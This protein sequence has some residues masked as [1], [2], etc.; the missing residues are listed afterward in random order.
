MASGTI[1]F[2]IVLDPDPVADTPRPARLELR[3]T[4]LGA[5][6]GLDPATFQARDSQ[7]GECVPCR[8]EDLEALP[9]PFD[10]VQGYW[11]DE[12]APA[13]RVTL[14]GL[15]RIYSVAAP[16][17][18]GRL[19]FLHQARRRA[20]TYRVRVQARGPGEVYRAAP[21]PWIGDGDPLFVEDAG[22]LGGMLHARPALWDFGRGGPDLLV[23]NI[24]GHIL[25]FPYEGDHPD[26]PYVT[27]AFV[28]ADGAN[29]DVGWYAAPFVCDWNGN[30]KPDLLVGE[31]GRVIYYENTGTAEAW[32]LELRGPVEA[33]GQP[34]SIPFEFRSKYPYIKREYIAAPSVFDWNG[35][36][37]ADLVIGGYL[38]GLIYHY[39][40]VGVHA[41]GTP[42]LSDAGH[43]TA[44]GEIIDVDWAAAP[45]FGDFLGTGLPCMI[46]GM[47][48][49]PGLLCYENVGTRTRPQLTRRPLTIE[50]A[51]G[52]ELPL[53][54][55][56][57]C[58]WDLNGN[59]RLDL[60]VG[61]GKAV[62][63]LEH[64]D[65]A[66]LAF[67]S[68]G[69][70]RQAWGA[71]QLGA[72]D[73][74]RDA[75]GPAFI[76][77]ND[78]SSLMVHRRDPESGT[79]VPE[80]M[81]TCQGEAIYRRYPDRD[82]WNAPYLRDLDA[83]GELELLMGDSVG[84]VWLHRS[85]GEEFD[86]G[87]QLKLTDGRPVNVGLDPSAEV[88]DWENHVGDRS[89]PVGVD[90]DGDG[91]WE[92]LVGDAHGTV[93]LFDNVGTNTEPVF[94]EGVPLFEGRGRVTIAA[95][96]WDGDGE[97][98]IFATW[99]SGEVRMFRRTATGW[100]D[101]SISIPWIPYP[102]PMVM[103][104]D[105]RGEPDL[106]LSGSYGF[107]HLFRRAFVEHGYNEGRLR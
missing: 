28:E 30:G 104:I 24:L 36:G 59:G 16:G 49:P 107:L 51:D 77:G 84:N 37:V 5:P 8:W 98:E 76:A 21:R 100:D 85:V 43:L 91:V 41:D 73:G 22:L 67:R 44:D 83:D 75:K 11:T 93:T 71:S 25:H 48:D 101:K 29:L 10:D 92:L 1:E 57:P 52:E 81:L 86:E 2:D 102:H 103:D 46:T 82:P 89:D 17:R 34:I 19:V 7:T 4:D 26:G 106:I 20:T 66:E 87:T 90:L 35:D 88:A 50:S 79:F 99:S 62:H 94:T 13:Q 96:D 45:C 23:G 40:S 18:H 58:P 15:G 38:T 39:Q 97:I 64:L 54:L 12:G 60:V 6:D 32:K 105:G 56:Y 42:E 9:D 63:L 33:D 61:S 74:F 14:A 80:R 78:G 69:P 47:M 72:A 55:T 95:A 31:G 3:S 65:G 70:L 68:G 27:G 53:S